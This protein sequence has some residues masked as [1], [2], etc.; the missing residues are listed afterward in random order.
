MIQPDR[1]REYL[2][3]LTPQ[4]RSS[5]L[6]ELERLEA[7]GTEVP[8]AASLLEN[9]R[10]E[11]RESGK[12]HH[13][14]ANASRHF[15]HPVEALLVDGAPE[16][17][18]S[19]HIL[20]SSLSAIWEW[21]T[22]DVLRTTAEKYVEQMRPLIASG[23]QTEMRKA[24]AAFQIK[25]VAYL[26]GALCS[27]DGV[28]RAR[29]KL[30]TYT[31]SRAVYGDLIKIMC[32]LDVRDALAQFNEALPSSIEKF[33]DANV[34]KITRLLHAFRKSHPEQVPFAL[35]LVA[36]R[37]KIHWQLILLATMAAP[38]KTAEQVAV[39]PYAM[40]VPMV[41]DRMEDKLSELRV[42]LKNERVLVAKEILKD[43]YDTEHAL[44]GYID[45]LDQCEWGHRLDRL[46]KSTAALVEAEIARFPDNVDHVLGSI[47]LRHHRSLAGRLSHLA[48]K[49][50]DA[51]S[52][53]AA[54]CLKLI[55]K[56]Y[57]VITGSIPSS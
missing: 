52:R 43:I 34:L 16:H 15:F 26:E 35:T 18:N 47:R 32:V 48:W 44:Q 10:A 6:I 1:I 9:L 12:T 17:E 20:R 57:C 37:L 7:C 56:Y 50:R 5:L 54:R 21:I 45:R 46:T 3:Q 31:T 8:G 29:S 30:A 40:V 51:L 53:G 27:A 11:F 36:K 22:Q 39:T 13:R 38:S 41:L 2:R 28:A 42:A 19:G 25:V 14:V 55:G 49:G 4:A 33:D 24:A 23:N